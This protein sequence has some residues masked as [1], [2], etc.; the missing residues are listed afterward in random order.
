MTAAMDSLHF[1]CPRCHQ[2]VESRFWGPCPACRDALAAVMVG[3]ARQV[4][5]GAYEPVMH[6]VPNQV[7]T[8]E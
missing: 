6:V 1:D 5:V 7:A 3:E 8:K 2:P 4:E